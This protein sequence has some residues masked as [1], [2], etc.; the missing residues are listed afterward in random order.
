MDMRIYQIYKLLH[1][2]IQTHCLVLI[3]TCNPAEKKCMALV[4][5]AKSSPKRVIENL[6]TIDTVDI[7]FSETILKHRHCRLDDHFCIE[8]FV[9]IQICHYQEII[10]NRNFYTFNHIPPLMDKPMPDNKGWCP[11]FPIFTLLI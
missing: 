2:L 6:R 11:V 9:H 3:L 4:S 7:H 1:A 5:L 10:N 8:W